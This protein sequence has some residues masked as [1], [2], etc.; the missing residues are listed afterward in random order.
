M[1]A[2][3]LE[4]LAANHRPDTAYSDKDPSQLHEFVERFSGR[5]WFFPPPARDDPYWTLSHRIANFDPAKSWSRVRSPVLLLYGGRDERVPVTESASAIQDALKRAGNSHCTVKF[6]PNA[7]HS[8]NLPHDAEGWPR[9]VAGF[10]DVLTTW[11][12]AQIIRVSGG[13]LAARF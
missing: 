9:R 1:Q 8:F 7:D 2:Q 6:Y 12:N 11:A 4:N 13:D 3:R 10:A 5:A